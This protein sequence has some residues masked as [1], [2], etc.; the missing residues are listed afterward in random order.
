MFVV[1]DIICCICVG[2][3]V[4]VWGVKWSIVSLCIVNVDVE[5]WSVY[6]VYGG[7]MGDCV[8]WFG[9][10]C[11]SVIGVFMLDIIGE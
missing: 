4:Y 1:V 5:F 11:L 2:F 7:N 10:C 3:D 8:S 6:C 9:V